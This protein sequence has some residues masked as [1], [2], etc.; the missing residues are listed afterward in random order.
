MSIKHWNLGVHGMIFDPKSG[1]SFQLNETA[2]LMLS[3]L[4]EDVTHEDIAA[5]IAKKF[6][7]AYESALTDVFEFASHLTNLSTAK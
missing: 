2:R 5:L 6:S 7:I 3:M 4:R 1:N